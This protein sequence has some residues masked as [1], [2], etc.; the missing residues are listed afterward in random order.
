MDSFDGFVT[1]LREQLDGPLPGTSA[2]LTMAPSYRMTPEQARVEGKS[3]R[4]AGVL[5]LLFPDGS[6]VHV[7]LTVRRDELPD[8]PGQIAFPGGQREAGESLRATALRE[9]HEEVGLQRDRVQ[10]LGALTPLY[11]PPSNFCVH[12]FVGVTAAPPALCPT[13]AEVAHILRVP[14]D[15]LLRPEARRREPWTLHGSTV[16]VPFFAV[17]DHTVWGATAMMLA[18][19]LAVVRPLYPSLTIPS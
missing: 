17:D 19:L 13:D 10:V 7:V 5:A 16:D 6:R 18:E 3:C 8:H 14:L 11:I 1:G 2:Q 4:E 9:A 12:P 15:H